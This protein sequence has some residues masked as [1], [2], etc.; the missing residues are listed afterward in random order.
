MNSSTIIG[1]T[2]TTTLFGGSSSVV[3]FDSSQPASQLGALMVAG[4]GNETLNGANS[5]AT[6]FIWGGSV[7]GANNS[8]IGGS[9]NDVLF[10]GVGNDSM[11]GGAGTNIFAF[12]NG[13]AGG[14]DLITD[15]SKSDVLWLAGYN[16]A[17]VNT[18]FNNATVSGGSLTVALSDNTKITFSGLT[19]ASAI[20]NNNGNIH[21][22]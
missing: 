9:G 13:L 5:S 11:T 21:F 19:S 7:S 6:E 8:L 10:V 17:S 12:T 2:G 15:F 14:T 22:A 18:A 4:T 3:N 16:Q 20:N 1:G